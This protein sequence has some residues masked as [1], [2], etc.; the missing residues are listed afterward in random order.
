MLTPSIFVLAD[1][2]A[3]T[4]Q[5]KLIVAGI[6]DTVHSKAVPTTHPIA[7]V[8]A[9]LVGP[10]ESAGKPAVFGID[11]V[12]SEDKLVEGQHIEL[13]GQ[14]GTHGIDQSARANII[15]QVRGLKLPHF[16][17]YA[18]RLTADGVEIARQSF[19]CA[20]APSTPVAGN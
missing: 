4:E 6:F 10:P 16:G 11:V 1:Y 12:D 13:T 17:E 18:V 5:D 14:V 19:F 7:F 3:V 9:Q 2:A 8:V 20:Q 15:A